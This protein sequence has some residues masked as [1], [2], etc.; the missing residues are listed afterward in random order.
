MHTNICNV[1]HTYKD[2]IKNLFI[3]FPVMVVRCWLIEK[4]TTNNALRS[5]ILDQ[6]MRFHHF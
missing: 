3:M 5:L 4:R 1:E 6:E 2:Q